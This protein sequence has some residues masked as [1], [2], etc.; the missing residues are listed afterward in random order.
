MQTKQ[1]IRDKHFQESGV[2]E[3]EFFADPDHEH[4]LNYYDSVMVPP[5]RKET[6]GGD[7]LWDAFDGDLG[8]SRHLSIIFNIFVFLQIFN[9]LNAR[10]IND[11]INICAG[12]FENSMFVI[13]WLI[14]FV[15]QIFITQYGSTLMKVSPQ[16]LGMDQWIVSFIISLTAL[17]VA[18]ALK[19]VPDTL[20]P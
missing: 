2:T 18:M 6:W 15:V 1:L 9:M 19:F 8:A 3:A 13:V 14:I 10:K 11:E 17:I 16:G 20:C 7:P 12:I 5:G 4:W